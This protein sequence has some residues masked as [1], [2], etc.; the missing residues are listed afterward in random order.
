MEVNVPEEFQERGNKLKY[1]YHQD[2]YANTNM[3]D[4]QRYREM[5][6]SCEDESFTKTVMNKIKL[7]KEEEEERVKN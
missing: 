2:K 7:P 1:S 4:G 3:F 6:F 5:S